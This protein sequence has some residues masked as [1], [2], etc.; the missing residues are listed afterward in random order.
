MQILFEELL[1]YKIMALI[2]LDKEGISIPVISGQSMGG[3]VGQMYSE[4]RKN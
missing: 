3:Y 1:P 4:K 2:V